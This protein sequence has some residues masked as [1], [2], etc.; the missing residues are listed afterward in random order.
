MNS[1]KE[2]FT[3]SKQKHSKEEAGYVAHTVKGQRCDEC[4]MWRAPNKCS[5]V[6]GDIKPE[7]WCKWWKKSKRKN[8]VKEAL[9][10]VSPEQE[11]DVID[12]SFKQNVIS[13]ILAGASTQS[14][15]N[16]K[17][18]DCDT[19]PFS[20]VCDKATEGDVI[21]S[22]IILNNLQKQIPSINFKEFIT[23]D[24]KVNRV[25]IKFTSGGEGG[26][27]HIPA[28]LNKV[29]GPIIILHEIAHKLYSI[30]ILTKEIV[31][32][33]L[34]AEIFTLART[35]E[36]ARVEKLMEK[37]YP[38]TVNVFKERA[39]YIIP[40]YKSHS[41]TKFAKIVD[42]LFLTLRGYSNSFNHNK[43]YLKLGQ[44]FV[45]AGNNRDLKVETV[46]K[47]AELI[48]KNENV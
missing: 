14:S 48:N 22:N 27:I 34:A 40:L 41:P 7:A 17:W 3:E 43:E 45:N 8:L 31:N 37:E 36:D 30:D 1:F 6:A 16:F 42:D 15:K 21:D 38:Q 25:M 24:P 13:D 23:V 20:N 46:I 12:R 29:L 33:P 4:T 5:A 18:G 47:L 9:A 44:Q 10:G 39:K 35:I 26:N 11:K 32:N 2:F 28:Q 19:C